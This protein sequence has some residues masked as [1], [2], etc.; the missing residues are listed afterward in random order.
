MTDTRDAD[1]YKFPHL[2]PGEVPVWREFLRRYGKRYDRFDYDVHVGRGTLP[3]PG[4]TDVYSS[5]YQWITKKRI[6]VVGWRG[7][8]ATIFEVRERAS[9]PLVG[10]V[11]GYRELWMMDNP[12]NDPPGMVLVCVRATPDD[13]YVAQNMG[14][15]IVLVP[16]PGRG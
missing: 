3:A 13:I 5:D 4:Q 12:E 10:Q 9:L 7:R 1:R 16:P 6:D 2:L 11:T 15:D 8:A 14:V